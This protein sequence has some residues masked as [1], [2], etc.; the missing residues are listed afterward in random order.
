LTVG[1][2]D[3]HTAF[4]AAFSGTFAVVTTVA[5]LVARR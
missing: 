3:V 1:A 2:D 5:E 4:L